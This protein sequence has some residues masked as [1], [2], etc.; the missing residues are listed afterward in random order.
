MLLVGN[1]S[2]LDSQRRVSLE[3]AQQFSCA[4]A[5]PYIECSAKLRINV[6]QAFHE[7]V[8]IIRKFQLAERPYIEDSYKRKSKRRCSILWIVLICWSSSYNKTKS[9][10]EK[11]VSY[12]LG[13]LNRK[14]NSMQ[15]LCAAMVCGR[16]LSDWH[17]QWNFFAISDKMVVNIFYEYN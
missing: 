13:H 5:M 17:A 16:L 10:E 9:E 8:R 3:E 4:A 1:K 11:R 7:L 12:L 15:S 14:Q 2:D 6:D